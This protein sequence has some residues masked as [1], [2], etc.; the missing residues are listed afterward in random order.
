[1]NRAFLFSMALALG[2]VLANRPSQDNETILVLDPKL[3]NAQVPNPEDSQKYWAAVGKPSPYLSEYYG[4][5]VLHPV[6]KEDV[7]RDF[8][9]Q[10]PSDSGG[11]SLSL[12]L[13][14]GG[15]VTFH[16]VKHLA[17]TDGTIVDSGHDYAW[18]HAADV[19]HLLSLLDSFHLMLEQRGL[20]SKYL[21]S[22]PHLDLETRDMACLTASNSRVALTEDPDRSKFHSAGPDALLAVPDPVHG[23]P[24]RY[25]D[26]L[27]IVQ[28]ETF[29]WFGI[30][31]YGQDV[32]STIDAFLSEPEGSPSFIAAKQKLLDVSWTYFHALE[33]TPEDNYYLRLIDICRRRQIRVYGMDIDMVY[34]LFGHGETPFGNMVRNSFWV[35]ALPLSGRGI[36]FGGSEHF[37]GAHRVQ[38]LPSL[39]VPDFLPSIYRGEKLLVFPSQ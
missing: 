30:E 38:G 20:A 19:D 34:D 22:N 33:K 25:A 39:F 14:G 27:D 4:L 3:I 29:D 21:I 2:R 1:M 26:I 16:F 36:L 6:T 17:K 10:S 9:T 31:M 37:K 7:V 35:Q 5:H 11:N 23:D 24:Q 28:N 18:F 32:Q 15:N 8:A 12:D 13:E